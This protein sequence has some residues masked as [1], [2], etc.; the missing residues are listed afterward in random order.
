[1]SETS[2][3]ERRH[4]LPTP[5]KHQAAPGHVPELDPRRR[6]DWRRLSSP[7]AWGALACAAVAAVGT[8]LG[9]VVA[10]RLAENPT[11]ALLALLALCVVGAS[12]VDTAG[13]VV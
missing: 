2:I 10:G 13:K 4:D 6:V 11:G 1:M 5:E 3:D 12:I 9:T 8:T 7:L